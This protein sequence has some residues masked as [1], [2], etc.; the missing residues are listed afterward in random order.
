MGLREKLAGVIHEIWS[1]WM[2]Y[3]LSVGEFEGLDYRLP[4]RYVKRWQRQMRTPWDVL[5]DGE[6]ERALD[7]ADRVMGIIR[8]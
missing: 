4:V 3:L 1:H 5:P 6:Q 8:P 7:M 2:G